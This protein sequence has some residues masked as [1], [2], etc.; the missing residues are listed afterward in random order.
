MAEALSDLFKDDDDDETAEDKEGIE[1][2]FCDHL[3]RLLFY[4]C[5]GI[6]V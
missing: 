4:F 1:E 2:D 6:I 3:S 5:L